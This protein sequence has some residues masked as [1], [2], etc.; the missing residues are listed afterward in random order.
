MNAVMNIQGLN[1]GNVTSGLRSS[2][3]DNKV[4]LN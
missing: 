3:Q 4:G 1:C 2:H